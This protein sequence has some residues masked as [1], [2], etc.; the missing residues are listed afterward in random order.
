MVRHLEYVQDTEILGDNKI[1][2][3]AESCLAGNAKSRTPMELN[4]WFCN[5]DS[6]FQ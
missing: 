2:L 6:F 3:L 4:V 1:L 5:E